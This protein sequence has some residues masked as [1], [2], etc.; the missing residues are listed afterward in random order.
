MKE[1][2]IHRVI[3]TL[4]LPEKITSLMAQCV[5]CGI[6]NTVC[7]SF[8]YGGCSPQS[9]MN[10]EDGNI[11]YCIGCGK[12]SEACT[13]TDPVYVMMHMHCVALNAKIPESYYITGLVAPIQENPA[14][15]ELPYIPSGDDAYLMAGCTVECSVPHLKYAAGVALNAINIKNSELPNASC[16]TLPV[17]FRS[18]SDETRE[19]YKQKMNTGS[20]EI[21]T[22][23]S[24]CSE[25]LTI[26]GLNA[27]HISDVF[28]EKLSEISKLRG[29]SLNVAIEPGCGLESS[30]DKFNEIAKAAGATLVGNKT[31]CCGKSVKDISGKLMAERQEEI[32]GA[33][34]VVVGCPLCAYKYDKVPGGTPVLHISE[35]I[36][37]ASGDD[38][39]LKYH[40]LKL[41]I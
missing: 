19:E 8:K 4:D 9:V 5:A 15:E 3:Y 21:I 14:R 40:N 23:C 13:N 35:L 30:L 22:I 7:P 12:C 29:V 2:I 6:C 37:L 25:E 41:K 36:A 33:D 17:V 31:G 27:K 28:Y 24:G 10:G 16:C 18:V 39:T 38:S 1:I 34:A 26:S 11:L 20:K 32:K